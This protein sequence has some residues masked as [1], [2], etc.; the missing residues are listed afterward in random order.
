MA[1]LGTVEPATSADLNTTARAAEDEAWERVSANLTTVIASSPTPAMLFSVALV[2]L[3]QMLYHIC[4]IASS[5]ALD[6]LLPALQQMCFRELR[7]AAYLPDSAT[8]VAEL[9]LAQAPGALL[10]MLN[11]KR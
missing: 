9:G 2:I 3:T 10:A 8:N 7:T 1:D 5:L 11:M 4:H 6:Y